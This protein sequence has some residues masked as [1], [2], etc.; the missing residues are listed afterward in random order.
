MH[1]SY[2]GWVRDVVTMSL[3]LFASSPTSI[4]DGDL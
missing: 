2:Q 3:A 1:E 4:S